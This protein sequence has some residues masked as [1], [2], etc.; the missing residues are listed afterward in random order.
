LFSYLNLENYHSKKR[1][2]LSLNPKKI[3]F[4]DKK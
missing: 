1:K 4:N 2:N 3:E